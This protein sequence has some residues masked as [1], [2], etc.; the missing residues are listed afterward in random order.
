MGLRLVNWFSMRKTGRNLR[1]AGLPLLFITDDLPALIP[2]LPPHPGLQP[3]L[4]N[5]EYMKRWDKSGYVTVL[6]GSKLQWG[7][8]NPH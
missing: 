6:T 1:S 4:K 3:G 5:A 7:K 2:P 8:A